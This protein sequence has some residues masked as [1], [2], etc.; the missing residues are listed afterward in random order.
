MIA[1]FVEFDALFSTKLSRTF[2]LET[3][4]IS[5]R[6][7]EISKGLTNEISPNFRSG[8]VRNF[9]LLWRNFGKCNEISPNLRSGGV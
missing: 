4:K 8:E 2:A 6:L 7:S 5:C 1:K 3:C 9:V